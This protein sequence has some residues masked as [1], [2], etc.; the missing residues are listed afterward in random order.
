MRASKLQPPGDREDKNLAKAQH[1]TGLDRYV[2]LQHEAARAK[3]ADGEHFMFA[4]R[5]I[6]QISGATRVLAGAFDMADMFQEAADQAREAKKQLEETLTAFR[7]QIQNDLKSITAAG[8]RVREESRKI[9]AGI[10]VAVK[11]LTGPEMQ[12]ALSNAERLVAALEAIQNLKT[13]RLA[14]AVMG[15]QPQRPTPFAALPEAER[16]GASG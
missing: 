6:R 11:Q 16:P 13:T 1:R 12:T 8:E 9:S 14:F 3:G 7:G 2:F 15:E 4:E 10:D 5:E